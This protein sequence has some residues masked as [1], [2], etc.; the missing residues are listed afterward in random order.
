MVAELEYYLLDD[1]F[2]AEDI[3]LHAGYGTV[4]G[5]ADIE[6]LDIVASTR[7]ESYNSCENTRAVL[8][9]ATKAMEFLFHASA[10]LSTSMSS[11][12]GPRDLTAAAT[13]KSSFAGSV[14][15]MPFMPTDFASSVKSG[16]EISVAK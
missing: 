5:R 8:D 10:S 3:D 1:T 4:L 11:N 14:T 12:T 9:I 13:T 7:D 16:D 2:G 15:F 6:H